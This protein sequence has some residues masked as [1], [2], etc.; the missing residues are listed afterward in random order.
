MFKF[1]NQISYR[2]FLGT[3]NWVDVNFDLRDL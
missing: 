1:W 3:K 2:D